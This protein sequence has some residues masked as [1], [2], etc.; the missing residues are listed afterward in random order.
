MSEKKVDSKHLINKIREQVKMYV[1]AGL[2]KVPKDYSV[3]NALQSAWFMI[4]EMIYKE[5]KGSAWISHQVVGNVTEASIAQS[6]FKMVVE[7]LNPFK[8][9]CAFIKRGNELTYQ[10]QYQGSIALAKR[11]SGVKEVNAREIYK[12]DEF[13]TEI[14]IAGRKY[15]K[16]HKQTLESMDG[17]IIGA[18]CVVIDKNGK[19]NLTVLT[20]KRIKDAWDQGKT[21]GDVHAKFDDEMSKKTVINRACKPYIDSSSDDAIMDVK[22]THIS[23]G[24]KSETT[25]IEGKRLLAIEDSNIEV[26]KDDKE[27]SQEEAFESSS[28]ESNNE[29]GPSY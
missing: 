20:K 27:V 22:P 21:K 25:A 6:M 7:G 29:D 3:E 15:I 13:E 18:Y 17:E 2:V 19:E 4:S 8:K 16:L 9:Q 14:D 23:I 28:E 1:D 5:K 11:Y 12:D 24:E 10:R 26:V